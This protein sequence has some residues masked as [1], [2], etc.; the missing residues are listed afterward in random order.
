MIVDYSTAV[1]SGLWHLH[2]TFD[3]LN[4]KCTIFV[5]LFL[6]ITNKM[7]SHLQIILSYLGCRPT[8]PR[9]R[10]KFENAHDTDI[11]NNL[12]E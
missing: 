5:D 8:S 10:M 11:T 9:V 7:L 3:I 2:I 4:K 6:A 12:G 1:I